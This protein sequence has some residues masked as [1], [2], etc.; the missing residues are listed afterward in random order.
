MTWCHNGMIFRL[1]TIRTAGLFGQ[2]VFSF[3][4]AGVVG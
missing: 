1:L 3:L 4:L 2:A